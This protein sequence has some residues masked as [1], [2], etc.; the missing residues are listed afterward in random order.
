[1]R[2]ATSSSKARRSSRG[3]RGTLCSRARCSDGAS[4]AATAVRAGRARERRSPPQVRGREGVQRGE[5]EGRDRVRRDEVRCRREPGPRALVSPPRS[6]AHHLSGCSAHLSV[7][8]A[9][10]QVTTIFGALGRDVVVRSDMVRAGVEGAGRGGG[11]ARGQ[12]PTGAP[13]VAGGHPDAR[14]HPRPTA[15]GKPQVAQVE[16]RL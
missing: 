13:P 5:A 8:C 14:R 3:R 10:N 15:R 12:A 6:P 16:D 2:K 9:G 1:M 11:G 4:P 7:A